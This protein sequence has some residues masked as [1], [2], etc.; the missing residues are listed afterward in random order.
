[1]EWKQKGGDGDI[2]NGEVIT[3]LWLYKLIR[4]VTLFL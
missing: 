3:K 4:K 2:E 1:M